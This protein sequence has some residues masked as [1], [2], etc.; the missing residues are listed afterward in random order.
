[1]NRLISIVS[2]S[3]FALII[4]VT[5][6]GCQ[7]DQNKLE[8]KKTQLE[9]EKLKRESAEAEAQKNLRKE[10]YSTNKLKNAQSHP[11]PF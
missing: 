1:M 6:Q 4:C 2:I 9:V 11:D 8:I 3:F 10:I 7:S 5:I